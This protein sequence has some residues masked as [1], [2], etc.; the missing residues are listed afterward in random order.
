[1]QKKCVCAGS[2]MHTIWCRA[3]FCSI[4]S[5]QHG[6]YLCAI[7]C[8]FSFIVKHLEH[9]GGKALYKSV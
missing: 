3:E 7:Y 9:F 8:M 1:M 6:V 4:S 2:I 5:R